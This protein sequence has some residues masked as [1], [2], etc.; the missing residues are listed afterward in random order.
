M[1]LKPIHA[2]VKGEKKNYIVKQ[3]A[4]IE[5]MSA[6]IKLGHQEVQK[7]NKINQ[8]SSQN[9]QTLHNINWWFN[10]QTG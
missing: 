2:Q 6:I 3:I 9:V 1:K 5:I 4:N 10:F 8:N 7:Q